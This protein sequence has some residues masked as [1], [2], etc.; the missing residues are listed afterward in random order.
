VR[1][2]YDN[3]SQAIAAAIGEIDKKANAVES[4]SLACANGYRD[5]INAI[6]FHLALV[7]TPSAED[8]SPT[9]VQGFCTLCGFGATGN[10]VCPMVAGDTPSAEVCKSC[11]G[12]GLLLATDQEAC[13]ICDGTGKE[14]KPSAV[15]STIALL[16]KA[17]AA[18]RQVRSEWG[19]A[20]WWSHSLEA[21]LA[22]EVLGEAEASAEERRVVGGYRDEPTPAP[23]AEPRRIMCKSCKGTGWNADLAIGG[24]CHAC[25]GKGNVEAPV[26]AAV[27]VPVEGR[28]F[29]KAVRDR[30]IELFMI[31]Q[32]EGYGGI[33]SMCEITNA[34]AE[35]IARAVCEIA[36]TLEGME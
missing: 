14:P 4:S 13:P 25:E 10:H 29:F 19:T 31:P 16:D 26:A 5:A 36:R 17:R 23:V 8:K 32:P 34:R 11:Y 21:K 35:A 15:E 18:L 24:H 27:G 9:I 30:I 33:T 7:P 22:R 6:S 2:S 20:S 12:S 28:S 1:V 3:L